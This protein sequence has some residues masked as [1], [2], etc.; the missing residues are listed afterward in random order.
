MLVSECPASAS[1]ESGQ[2]SAIGQD[3]SAESA[4]LSAIG[5]D[6]CPERLLRKQGPLWG[7]EKS[8]GRRKGPPH[9]EH[10]GESKPGLAFLRPGE[11]QPLRPFREDSVSGKRGCGCRW[12]TQ[13]KTEQAF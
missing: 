8:L 2:L 13:M 7:R 5:Q 3:A 11:P 1:A 4:Q 12:G 10:L 6:T 9:L